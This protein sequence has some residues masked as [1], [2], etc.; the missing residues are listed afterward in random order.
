MRIRQSGTSSHLEQS[1]RQKPINESRQMALKMKVV[2]VRQYAVFP[3]GVISVFQIKEDGNDLFF[4]G[5]SI[6]NVTIE[7]DDLQCYSLS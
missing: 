3:H 1:T 2:K 7:P 5:K 6:M 4:F